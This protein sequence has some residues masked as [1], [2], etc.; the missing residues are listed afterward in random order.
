MQKEPLSALSTGINSSG[1]D[2]HQQRQHNVSITD[3]IKCGKYIN[4][5][6]TMN[7][8]HPV[9]NPARQGLT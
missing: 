4:N 6:D 7:I 2:G 3:I 8:T 1:D 5:I 9:Y